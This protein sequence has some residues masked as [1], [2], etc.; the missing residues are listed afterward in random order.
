MGQLCR[1]LVFG[2]SAARQHPVKAA[3]AGVR[4]K[5]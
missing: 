3:G 5:L 2:A 4:V 1:L